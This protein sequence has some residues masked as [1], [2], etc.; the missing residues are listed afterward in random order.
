MAGQID[1]IGV[2]HEVLAQ[3]RLLDPGAYPGQEGKIPL[4]ELLVRQHRDGGGVV[5]IDVGDGLRAEV[6]ADQ[7]LGGG[8]LLAFENEAGGACPQV[9]LEVPIAW[10][11]GALEALQ[12][13]GQL[14]GRD[15]LLLGGHDF[16]ENGLVDGSPIQEGIG[17]GEGVEHLDILAKS[18]TALLAAVSTD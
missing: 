7:A 11:Q 3:H 14:A 8:G 2:N 13:L 4:E 9:A 16:A 12:G 1:L 17:G 10:H 6:V 5:A 15:P 18:G